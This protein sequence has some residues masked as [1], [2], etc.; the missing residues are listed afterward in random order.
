MLQAYWFA[1]Q[2]SYSRESLWPVPF[3]LDRIINATLSL[4]NTNSGNVLHIVGSLRNWE[5]DHTQCL[6]WRSGNLTGAATSNAGIEVRPWAYIL[7]NYLPGWTSSIRENSMFPSQY[8]NGY[9]QAC[10]HPEW[11]TPLFNYT[12]DQIIE[13]YGYTAENIENVGRILFT[14]G[15]FDPGSSVGPPALALSGYRNASRTVLMPSIAHTEEEFSYA[16]SPVGLSIWNDRV[17]C[18]WCIF[19]Q[20][21][22][23]LKSHS[24]VRSSSS[25]LKHG[26]L[27]PGRML[28]FI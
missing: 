21:Y 4:S 8:T 1:T 16:I 26:S 20:T 12:N 9:V 25:R 17:R 27:K 22:S 14:Q 13:E 11:Q 23:M 24:C 7:C 19:D 15:G 3:V 28:K 2:F 5:L 6:D 10:T 18:P